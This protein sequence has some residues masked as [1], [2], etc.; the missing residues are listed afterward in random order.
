M[1]ELFESIEDEIAPAFDVGTEIM[2]G[3]GD[4]SNGS[5]IESLVFTVDN[6]T[7]LNAAFDS[8]AK[9]PDFSKGTLFGFNTFDNR[10]DGTFYAY[11]DEVMATWPTPADRYRALQ[12][13]YNNEK[14]LLDNAEYTNYV[15]SIPTKGVG[16]VYFNSTYGESGILAV[17][18]HSNGFKVHYR[19]D[20]VGDGGATEPPYMYQNI[21]G[22]NVMFYGE[23]NALLDIYNVQGMDLAS[24]LKT[25]GAIETEGNWMNNGIAFSMHD[26]GTLLPGMALYFDAAD[27]VEDARQDIAAMSEFFDAI[28]AQ[29]DEE[30]PEMADVITKST[31]DADGATLNK[32]TF[33]LSAVPE[34]EMD[35]D[36]EMFNEI[37]T[38]PIE[39]YYGLTSDDYVVFAL[40]ND[41]EEVLADSRPISMN[42][43]IKEAM[44]YLSGYPNG[45]TYISMENMLNYV[46]VW[47][48]ELE[49]QEP[50]PAELKDNYNQ[51]IEYLSTID[52]MINSEKEFGNGL[53]Y[54]KVN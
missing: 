46:D 52:Y 4:P 2:F 17:V 9:K 6:P 28:V 33:D 48:T 30:S 47:V 19:L 54:V 16:T 14:D 23:S 20:G 22:E 41:F 12:N 8:L 43:D 3:A 37:V 1:G 7:K 36:L 38:D 42:S 32:I 24:Q 29:M 11:T 15:A 18:P 31:V 10:A 21:P 13:I 51:V 25:E 27:Y 40:Y 39:F 45:L 44:S 53:M 26:T 35:S 34:E 50:M 5:A 49:K